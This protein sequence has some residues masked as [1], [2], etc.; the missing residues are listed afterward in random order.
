MFSGDRRV[1]SARVLLLLLLCVVGFAVPHAKAF[2]AHV[3]P[4]TTPHSPT[5][6][7]FSRSTNPPSYP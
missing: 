4:P 7:Q 5:T 2:Q 3:G 1:W 6:G